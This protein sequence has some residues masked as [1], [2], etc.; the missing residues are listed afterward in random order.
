MPL[1]SWTFALADQTGRIG[2]VNAGVHAAL[3]TETSLPKL[4]DRALVADAQAGNARRSKSW[5]GATT[6]MYC[7]WR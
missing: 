3:S 4:E 7:G 1:P 2:G 6:A 5:Y